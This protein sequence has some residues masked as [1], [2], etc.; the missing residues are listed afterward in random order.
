MIPIYVKPENGRYFAEIFRSEIVKRLKA[1]RVLTTYLD[2]DD[3]LNVN[4]VKDIQQRT[5]S[6]SDGTFINYNDG[7]QLY[8]EDGYLMKIHY[9]TNH[10]VSIVEKGDSATLKGIFGYGGHSYIEKIKDVKIE[11]IKDLP[12]WCEVVHAKNMINDAYFLKAKM[13]RDE[14]LLESSF[15][16]NEKVRYGVG[17]YLFKFIPRYLKTFIRRCGYK[18]YGRHW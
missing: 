13:M 18:V 1:P 7:Y 3:A 9:P 14:H 5:A 6:V 8:E 10:F 12:M 17:L 11:H 16:I 2:N 4:F 15:G